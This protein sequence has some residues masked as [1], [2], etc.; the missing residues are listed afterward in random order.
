GE[1][2][3]PP[4]PVMLTKRGAA[5]L[6]RIEKMMDKASRAMGPLPPTVSSVERRQTGEKGDA[7][8]AALE[9]R[10]FERN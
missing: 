8:A 4:R 3:P 1:P 9:G 5:I 7:L 2:P 6:S 10:A